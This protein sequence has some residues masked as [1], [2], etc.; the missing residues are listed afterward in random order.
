M[1]PSEQATPASSGPPPD[2]LVS[3][4]AEARRRVNLLEWLRL[5]RHAVA[6][7]LTASNPDAPATG[8]AVAAI[9]LDLAQRHEPEASLLM[10]YTLLQHLYGLPRRQYADELHRLAGGRR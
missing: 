3:V 8:D 9:S 4:L 6:D 7:R 2:D 1:K 10:S 5:A